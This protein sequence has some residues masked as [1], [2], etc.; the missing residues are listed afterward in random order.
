MSKPSR[1]KIAHIS[2]AHKD[3]D[4][5]IFHKECSS[6]AN[7]INKNEAEFD[8]HLILAG[9]EERIQENVTIHTVPIEK[10][11]RLKRMWKTVNNVYK[12]A[13]EI[14]ADI[15]HLHDPELLRIALKLKRNG[16]KVIYDAHEDLPRQ[17]L[18]KD[19]LKFKKIISHTAEWYEDF[20]AK[21]LDAIVTATP[22]I[23]ERFIKV[24]TNT[25]NINNY[26]LLSE[27]DMSDMDHPKQN[28]ICFIGGIS[29]IRGIRELVES[30]EFVDVE[31]AIAGSFPESFKTEIIKE[32]GW[33]KVEELGFINREESLKLKSESI[34]GLVTFLPL[35]NH[36][37]AQPNKIFEYM[38][39]GL[40]VIG[41]RFPLWEAII[42][43][44]DCGI[45]VDPENPKEIA[46]AIQRIKD[47]PQ[48]AKAMGERGKKQVQEVY[49]WAIEEVK[50]IEL[51][52]S[53][54]I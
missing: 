51:Y 21:K 25:V 31:C 45:C 5:R 15:Y 13:L 2:S 16:K 3:L 26:P 29:R 50:L 42:E 8:V 39:S 40:P 53:L 33:S 27:V 11:S 44:N 36:I 54:L 10:N 47:N 35:P 14:D 23:K 17:I 43:K 22:F 19:Y 9:V 1:Y 32:N 18:G 4:V 6:L 7:L 12:K 49:N 48:I 34:A 30:L 37:N 46:K 24:N 20:I 28:K 52:R 41:S 38:A